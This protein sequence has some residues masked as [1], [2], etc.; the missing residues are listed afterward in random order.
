MVASL[1]PVTHAHHLLPQFF[2]ATSAE[3]QFEKSG[4]RRLSRLSKLASQLTP[5]PKREPMELQLA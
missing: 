5:K 3:S 4:P 1:Q 2:I